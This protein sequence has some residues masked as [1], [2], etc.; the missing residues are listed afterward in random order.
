MLK[1]MF[2]FK[3]E[4]LDKP[5]RW[6]A[7]SFIGGTLLFAL[8][9]TI[10]HYWEKSYTNSVSQLTETS[11][12]LDFPDAEKYTALVGLLLRPSQMPQDHKIRIVDMTGRQRAIIELHKDQH[13]G[14]WYGGLP[15]DR[16]KDIGGSLVLFRANVL[17]GTELSIVGVNEVDRGIW[18]YR[19]AG[20]IFNGGEL[21]P[22]SFKHDPSLMS[23]VVE[24]LKPTIN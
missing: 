8:V 9:I 19:M 3:L 24:V 15:N 18:S 10:G 23:P 11:S 17:D 2:D 7:W 22:V 14:H 16:I 5:Y 4:G 1:N 12:N 21:G 20:G 6:L 13:D